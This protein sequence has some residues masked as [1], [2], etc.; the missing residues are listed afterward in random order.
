MATATFLA[1]RWR[2]GTVD[3][4]TR[5]A[6]RTSLLLGLRDAGPVS[7][8]QELWLRIAL[9]VQVTGSPS[10]WEYCP[11][12]QWLLA[13]SAS[14]PLLCDEFAVA[15]SAGQSIRPKGLS[16][17]GHIRREMENLR[18]GEQREAAE[19]AEAEQLLDEVVA[20][21]LGLTQQVLGS[22]SDAGDLWRA[23]GRNNDAL[24]MLSDVV[25]AEAD[26]MLDV[27]ALPCV[28]AGWPND[29]S[30]GVLRRAAN[31][32][33]R[34]S[35][36]CLRDLFATDWHAPIGSGAPLGVPFIGEQ[37][38]GHGPSRAEVAPATCAYLEKL[39][40]Q[41]DAAAVPT[42]ELRLLVAFDSE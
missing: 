2:S 33:L 3:E 25:S 30:E 32:G 8:P 29:L 13:D 28:R 19:A 41:L 31:I 6:R 10:R 17:P 20:A 39:R 42:D 22:S 12:D 18:I 34:A 40:S 27:A 35:H 16:P 4:C 37:I 1:E 15:T 21:S 5:R 23:W 38:V 14:W 26:P 11:F 9:C 24:S 36:C 7:L